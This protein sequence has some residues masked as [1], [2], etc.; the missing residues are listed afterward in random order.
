METGIIMATQQSHLNKSRLDKFVL[1]FNLPPILKESKRATSAAAN[2]L[3][4]SLQFSVYGVVVPAVNVPA[5]VNQFAG[6]SIKTS[7][8]NR[9]AYEDVTV[10]FNIDNRFKNYSVIHKWLN[11]LNDEKSGIYDS[12]DLMENGRGRIIDRGINATQIDYKKEYTTNMSLHGLDEY[13][14]KIIDFTYTEAFPITLGGINFNYQNAGEIVCSFT[15]A[16]SQLH[17]KR[18]TIS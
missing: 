1:S 17:F 4:D 9:P 2:E 16:F 18:V 8:F 5:I 11:I 7:S 15:F 3:Q 14:K 12:G 6:Q 10:D 13:N